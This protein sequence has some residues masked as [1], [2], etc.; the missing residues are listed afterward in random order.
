MLKVEHIAKWASLIAVGTIGIVIL[1]KLANRFKNAPFNTHLNM[2]AIDV[3]TGLEFEHYVARLLS[4]QGFGAIR[5]TEQYDYGV[6]IIAVRDG[7]T[8]GI[9]VKRY[10]GLVKADA[11]RQVMT[12][13][14]F[15]DCDRGMVITNSCFS[16]VAQKLAMA[17]NCVLV[18]RSCL[19]KLLR[20]DS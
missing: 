7:I 5:M 2:N 17:N 19:L 1:L 12:A 3:M 10:S 11:V 20:E 13:L 9:Q 14:R 6:D 18:N 15:Y 16:Y 4:S 8:W